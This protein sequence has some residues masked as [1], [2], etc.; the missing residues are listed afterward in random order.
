MDQTVRRKSEH[1]YTNYNAAEH[2]SQGPVGRIAH[3]GERRLKGFVTEIIEDSSDLQ[4]LNDLLQQ[5]KKLLREGMYD[6]LALKAIVRSDPTIIQSISGLEAII[7]L[8]QAGIGNRFRNY[9]IVNL[10]YN[11]PS[12]LPSQTEIESFVAKITEAGK[13]SLNREVH[14]KRLK[15]SVNQAVLNGI[16]TEIFGGPTGIPIKLTNGEFDD[17]CKLLSMHC[18]E[19]GEVKN[20]LGNPNN[21]TIVVKNQ[22]GKI[23]GIMMAELLD[24]RLQNGQNFKIV[25]PTNSATDEG[26]RQNGIYDIFMVSML[27]YLSQN[28]TN[29]GIDFMYTETNLHS[30]QVYS[31][32][33]HGRRIVFGE[34]GN[35][36]TR[37]L[38]ILPNHTVIKQGK[39][40][41][42]KLSSFVVNYV[43]QVLVNSIDPEII[44]G[45]SSLKRNR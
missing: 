21:L 44:C 14:M 37:Y 41:P 17:I 19:R 10:G 42:E 18:Y 7:P 20:I 35:N 33:Q 6:R 38:G 24:I 3:S 30:R 31:L 28:A 2:T 23:I 34:N 5:G 11:L 15:S 27:G 45:L 12:R 16:S 25:E 36:Q 4:F 1:Y 9:S 29:L 32:Y 13:N 40:L 43:D 22:D 26:N 39:N 8:E